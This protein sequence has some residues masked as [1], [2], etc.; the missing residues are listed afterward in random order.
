M[1]VTPDSGL[2]LRSGPK[3]FAPILRVLPRGTV[4]V[5]IRRDQVNG[6][7]LVEVGGLKG[8]MSTRFLAP[9]RQPPSASWRTCKSL[10]KLGEQVNRAYPKRDRTHDGTVGDLAHQQ[11]KSEHNP[12]PV[13][14]DYP[15][16]TPVVRARDITH[17]PEGGLDCRVLV[18]AL[19][20]SRDPRILYVI[21]DETI[22][23]SYDRPGLPAWKP[24]P[25]TGA[26]PHTKHCHISV[27]ADPRLF[28]SEA[29]WSIA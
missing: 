3:D 2:R 19:L 6:W 29:P 18:G 7:S 23:R 8:W 12:S 10:Q 11:R 27:S 1:V 5:E 20:R 26:N 15:D 22:W 21:W 14:A 9:E 17:D 16:Q 4:V 24:Q 25:Y 13:P 28:D